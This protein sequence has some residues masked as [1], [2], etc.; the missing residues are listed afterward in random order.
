[1]DRNTYVESNHNNINGNNNYELILEKIRKEIRETERNIFQIGNNDLSSIFDEKSNRNSQLSHMSIEEK[2][3]KKKYKLNSK[4]FNENLEI[5]PDI[6]IV[7]DS[8]N[9]SNSVT[10]TLSLRSKKNNEKEESSEE[11][12]IKNNSNENDLSK[13][14]IKTD[15]ESLENSELIP[16]DDILTEQ[17]EFND[18][19]PTDISLSEESGDEEGESNTNN[20][21]QNQNNEQ[22]S[23][24]DQETKNIENNNNIEVKSNFVDNLQFTEHI[25]SQVKSPIDM[26]TI[27]EKVY[28]LSKKNLKKEKVDLFPL[29]T[30]KNKHQLNIEI[31]K[32]NNKQPQYNF[33]KSY[34]V[35]KEKSSQEEE[36]PTFVFVDNPNFD[37]ESKSLR[38]I[39]VATSKGRVLKSQFHCQKKE[40]M[41]Q[42]IISSPE[43]ENIGITCMD[44]F[45][46]YMI[47]GHENGLI[48]I[49]EN[50]EILDKVQDARNTCEILAIKF[51]KITFKKKIE[52]IYSDV[53]GKVYYVKRLKIYIITQN[54]CKLIYDYPLYPVYK[55]QFL[56]EDIDLKISKK[57][58]ILLAFVSLECIRTYIIRPKLDDKINQ[59]ID[60]I[61][62]PNNISSK[63]FYFD[64]SYGAG[65]PPI[66]D[67]NNIT[68]KENESAQ[69]M[70]VTSYEKIL[71]LYI[72]NKYNYPFEIA[73]YIH[74]CYILR[75]AFIS[76]SFLVIVDSNYNMKLINTFDFDSGKYIKNH[77]PTKN[78]LL[79]YDKKDLNEKNVLR[80][81]KVFYMD[82]TKKNCK[83]YIA[84]CFNTI[85]PL[86]KSILILQ[87][88]KMVHYILLT[89]EDVLIN[90]ANDQELE[91]LLWLSITVLDQKKNLLTIQSSQKNK[92]FL[93]DNMINLLDSFSIKFLTGIMN[94]KN[95]DRLKMYFEYC[96]KTN[97]FQPLYDAAETLAP[98]GL[99]NNLYENL[100]EYILN[101]Y[102]SNVDLKQ[103][104]LGGY[105][106]YFLGHHDKILLCKIL[107]LLKV[108]NLCK[109]E[110]IQILEK[111]RLINPYIYAKINENGI[112]SDFFKP[113]E[114][115]FK[116][117]NE[118]DKSELNDEISKEYFNL[119]SS[120][121]MKY[122]NDKTLTCHDYLGHKLF[123]YCNKCMSN[124][125]YPRKSRFT[126]N[127][128]EETNKK[129]I[130][131]LTLSD[132]MEV[133]LKFD[134]FSYFDIIKKFFM[135]EKL[136]KL[137]EKDSDSDEKKL[138]FYG[139]DEFVKQHL[140]NKPI[141]SLDEKYF[142]DEIKKVVDKFKNNDDNDDSY[143]IK[144]DFYLM[145][146]LI[147]TTRRKKLIIDKSV[148]I[149][150]VKFFINFDPEKI[151]FEKD[152]FNCH[153]LPKNVVK[154]KEYLNM[155]EENTL[156]LLKYLYNRNVFYGTDIEELA[157]LPGVNKY[158]SIKIFLYKYMTKFDKI[159]E[160]KIQ[161]YENKNPEINK[162]NNIEN[163]FKWINEIFEETQDSKNTHIVKKNNN[164]NNLHKIFKEFLKQ[165]FEILG[166]ISSSELFNIL[167]KWYKDEEEN[168]I[169]SMNNEI[170][171]LMKYN[172]ITQYLK[173]IEKSGDERDEKYE[174]FCLIKINLLIKNN[175][176]EQIIKFLENRKIL[177]NR[178]I[179]EL[180]TLNKVTDGIIFIYQKLE[181]IDN[182]INLSISEIDKIFNETKLLLEADIKKYNKELINE[183]LDEIKRYL[184]LALGVC[185]TTT[186]Y[187]TVT[188]DDIKESW[189]KLLYKI[190]DL[191]KNLKKKFNNQIRISIKSFNII[192]EEQI[193]INRYEKV[194][195]SLFENMELI[196][197]KMNDCIPLPM[198]LDILCE[199]FKKSEFNEF[200]KILQGLFFSIHSTEQILK[201]ISNIVYS[202]A[203]E[204][205]DNFLHETKKGFFTSFEKCHFCGKP[206]SE[207][208]KTDNLIY[209]KC[210]HI[211]HVNC[212]AREG[213]RYVCYHCTVK[214]N[215]GSIITVA[216]KIQKRKRFNRQK[217][218][219]KEEEEID[220]KKKKA[221]E[222]KKCLKKLKNIREK[223]RDLDEAF[224]GEEFNK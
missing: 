133:L 123:W 37:P 41:K 80:E 49:W 104:F 146:T 90:L 96:I 43:C 61:R 174:K 169:F 76:N 209:F 24:Q 45:E 131:F 175:Y 55:F 213:P 91:K 53:S 190:Y 217:T 224:I 106:K 101:G 176:K 52:F 5:S 196:L 77:D 16:N 197:G 158:N 14:L 218:K 156:N 113:V 154:Y 48:L 40:E 65:F 2:F 50:N 60:S 180:L 139:L 81:K 29:T 33:L 177:W 148:L 71:R 111:N 86:N 72:I 183:N 75:V 66:S 202:S 193:K 87:K 151:P 220:E 17:R 121:D 94:S 88:N 164:I 58:N 21:D 129:I 191:R 171:D 74:D 120:R 107:M 85:V 179:L 69:K 8:S 134:S 215:D 153:I 125:E 11:E 200:L 194:V 206:I 163:L 26:I 70:F 138:P 79:Y 145:T 12:E 132:K 1:M 6:F 22:N 89:W 126:K 124:E 20:K 98:R 67:N 173:K 198:I 30:Y 201:F 92:K 103:D 167:N 84:S 127:L 162:E 93:N 166:K 207:N 223:I 195:Q 110:I 97:Y 155:I 95:F 32:E 172:Y 108:E 23:E 189:L 10:R 39:Y 152:K 216:S 208:N 35:L 178:K 57:K 42:E 109:G 210:G 114:Y 56:I 199:K 181:D 18:L 62:K 82:A 31:L 187:N 102:F 147:C 100:S 19:I 186:D 161:E 119:I 185:E 83:K 116:I 3:Q 150:A 159:L 211:Y 157:S 143:F 221:N 9:V 117:F 68:I 63:D 27:G 28:E 115:L 36:I 160:I 140:D 99:V 122:Y 136:Y 192:T 112:K 212:C 219:T 7:S 142:Y 78:N 46:N 34:I 170:S 204:G 64:C 135:R 184:E 130:L 182:C 222:K 203:S 105:I 4:L 13:L 118:Y 128:F 168:V 15:Q 59:S 141:K 54:L 47:T 25:L 73:H 214:E 38:F 51:L 205:Y 149:D 165:N 44:I 188:E 137:I 144:Y